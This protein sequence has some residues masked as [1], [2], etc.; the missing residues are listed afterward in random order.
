M[1]TNYFSHIIFMDY[2]LILKFQKQLEFAQH[3]LSPLGNLI[4][5]HK[6]GKI[7]SVGFNSQ[8]LANT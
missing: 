6:I 7:A 3:G 8:L 4:N 2:D 5:M 1:K